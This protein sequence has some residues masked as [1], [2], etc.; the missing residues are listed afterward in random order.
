[1]KFLWTTLQVRDMDKS[2]SFYQE[3][4]G[5]KLNHRQLAGPGIEM[6]F[7]GEGD[8]QIELICNKNNSKAFNGEGI[9]I[10]FKVDSL[11]ETMKII[12]EKGIIVTKEIFIPNPHV[13]F[14]FVNDPNSFQVQFVEQM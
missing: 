12:R 4:V 8:T 5:L 14:F 9:T 13:K 7:L 3:I 2:L 6:A 11:E 10:G 1:M